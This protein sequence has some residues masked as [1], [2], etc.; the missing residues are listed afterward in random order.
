MSSYRR[1]TTNNSG[2][3]VLYGA[4]DF[5]VVID[6]LNGTVSNSPPAKFKNTVNKVKFW[7][8]VLQLRNQA[9]TFDLTLRGPNGLAANRDLTFPAIAVN[10]TLAALLLTQEFSTKRL[11]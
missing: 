6:L 11:N 5:H 7:D 4:N 1:T 3:S 2:D 10:D 8:N 9:D